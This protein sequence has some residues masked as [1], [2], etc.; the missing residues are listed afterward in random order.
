MRKFLVAAALI[1]HAHC[2]CAQADND[3]FYVFKKDWSPAEGIKDAAYFMQPLKEN[4]TTYVCRYYQKLGPMVKQ[5]SFKDSNLTIPNGFF[6]WYNKKGM[7]DSSGYVVNGKKDHQWQYFKNDVKAYMIMWYDN[8]K[9]DRTEN[10]AAKTIT[11][12]DGRIENKPQKEEL[13]YDTTNQHQ[14]QFPGGPAAWSTY[15]TRN[16]NIPD[17]LL[18]IGHGGVI[19]VD[20]LVDKEGNIVNVTLRQSLEWSADAEAIRLIKRGPKWIPAEQGGRRVFYRQLQSIT[21]AIN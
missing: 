15:L 7:I 13:K 19:T 18:G 8:G 5:E 10:I 17:R 12:A 4:D 1:I 14:A 16:L 3:V 11:Y 21:M 2:V 20:F 9:W 6:A